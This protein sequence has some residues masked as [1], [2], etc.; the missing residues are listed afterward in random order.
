MVAFIIS[1]LVGLVRQIL[2][3][4]SFGTQADME[5]FNAANRVAESIFNL[6]AGGAL[7]SA[8]IPTFTALLST[9]NRERAWRLASSVANLIFV[10]SIIIGIIAIVFSP[11]IVRNILAPGF[12]EDPQKEQLT[13][14][15]MR[16]MMPSA[17]IFGM[18]GLVMGILNSHQSFFF[19]AIAPAMY[20]FGMIFGVVVLSPA[21]G[22]FGLAWGVLIG[23]VLHLALQIPSLMRLNGRYTWL[24][25][26]TSPDVR[27][28]ARLMAPRLLGVAIVQLNFWINTRL[29]SRFVEGSV[30]GVVLAFTLMLMP[31]AAIAQSIAIAALPTFSSQVALGRLTEM[32]HSLSA[33][34]RGAMFFSIPAS[35]GLIIL[36]VPFVSLLYQRG[37]F[38]ERSTELVAWALL[39]YAAGLAGHGLVEILSRAFYSLH[40]TKTP[41]FVGIGAM[42]LN[43]GFSFLFTELFVR[44]GWMGHGGLALANSIATALEA[45]ALFFLMKKRLVGLEGRLL[46]DGIWRTSIASGVMCVALFYWRFATS[47][48][49]NL[50]AASGGLALG[51]IVFVIFAYLLKIG[52]MQSITALIKRR[53][54][55]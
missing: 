42:S 21:I 18:S 14:E 24:E 34:L 32:R 3:A 35:V 51:V 27:E 5:A 52:E 36:R 25:G 4:K 23:A 54:A 55:G 22:I 47:Q 15:L 44:W 38:D 6:V 17:V 12:A 50:F 41:V 33:A 30:T 40:D 7:A 13:V 9:E 53:I 11:W 10:L 28:V 48:S 20:Q 19:P 31:Q 45:V 8:F 43:I 29:A 37:E 2:V 49:S 1:N 46:L 39:F 16:L 26:M